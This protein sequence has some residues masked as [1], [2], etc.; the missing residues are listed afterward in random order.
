[1]FVHFLYKPEPQVNS[2]LFLK[3]VYSSSSSESNSSS[4]SILPRLL[5]PEDEDASSIKT[6]S[7]DGHRGSPDT[8]INEIKE[9][10]ENL[11]KISTQSEQTI[12]IIHVFNHLFKKIFGQATVKE[13][14]Q[15]HA[16]MCDSRSSL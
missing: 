10:A 4:E 1:M 13:I 2:F 7:S 12:N 11:S 16:D 3:L 5:T 8:D 9:L 6:Y 15:R 14:L